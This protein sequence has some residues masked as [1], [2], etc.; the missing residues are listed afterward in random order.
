[1]VRFT[2][3]WILA[4]FEMESKGFVRWHVAIAFAALNNLLAHQRKG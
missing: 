1:M 4:A 2:Q 3:L